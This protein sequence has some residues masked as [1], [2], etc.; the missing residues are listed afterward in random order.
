[1]SGSENKTKF[2]MIREVLNKLELELAECRAILRG[3]NHET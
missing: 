2:T 3:E 1:M